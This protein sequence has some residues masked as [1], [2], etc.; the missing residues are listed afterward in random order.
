MTASFK[1][2]GME[3]GNDLNAVGNK[4]TFCHCCLSD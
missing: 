3:Q 2:V 4:E 1:W